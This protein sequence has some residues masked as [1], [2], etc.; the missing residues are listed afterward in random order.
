MLALLLALS[1]SPTTSQAH[2]LYQQG[3]ARELRLLLGKHLDAFDATDSLLAYAW[4]AYLM[5]GRPDRASALLEALVLD[6]PIDAAFEAALGESLPAT[7]ARFR[8]WLAEQAG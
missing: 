1:Q 3:A 7:E 6:R 8:L 5:E 2:E 4:A